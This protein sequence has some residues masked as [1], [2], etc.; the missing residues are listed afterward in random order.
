VRHGNTDHDL[1]GWTFLYKAATPGLAGSNNTTTYLLQDV[2]QPEVNLR[3]LPE[4]GGKSRLEGEYLGGPP[5][6]I[7]EVCASSAAY[8]LH[9]KLE[10]YEAAG[11]QEY[12]TVLVYEKEIRWHALKDGK[13]QAVLPGRDRVWRSLV[14][15]GLWL[16]GEAFLKSDTR[17]VVERLQEGINSA[18]HQAFVQELAKRRTNPS[19]A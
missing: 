5:E 4:Y 13:Y 11:V 8:D 6:F 1:S 7:G 18:E 19:D 15:P 12:L 17:R 16:E 9:E 14:F 3:L 2:V 10:L